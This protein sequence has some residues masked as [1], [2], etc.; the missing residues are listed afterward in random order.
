MNNPFLSLVSVPALLVAVLVSLFWVARDAAK[1]K[2]NVAWVVLLCFLTWP[3]G[4]L[5]WR[6]VRPPPPI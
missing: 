6:S 5:I 1:R 4:F 3:I 2:R